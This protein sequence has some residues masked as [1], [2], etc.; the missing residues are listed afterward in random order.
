MKEHDYALTEEI[1]GEEVRAV[2]NSM[3]GNSSPG[4]D[5]IPTL[6]Y[7]KFISLFLP[8]VVA[9]FNGIL[10]RGIWSE[11]WNLTTGIILFKKGNRK[12]PENYRLI[13]LA[14][15]LSKLFMKIME[16]R[17]SEWLGKYEI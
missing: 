15:S 16:M 3:K 14:S 1:T 7:K 17:L 10:Y 5:G 9:I 4:P 13:S 2:L 6:F 12:D 8:I 11:S